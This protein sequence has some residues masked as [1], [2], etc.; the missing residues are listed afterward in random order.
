MLQAAQYVQ[1]YLDEQ[2]F[3]EIKIKARWFTCCTQLNMYSSISKNAHALLPD[4]PLA[5]R[6]PIPA[7]QFP[8]WPAFVVA[9]LRGA[10]HKRNPRLVCGSSLERRPGSRGTWTFLFQGRLGGLRGDGILPQGKIVA[11]CRESSVLRGR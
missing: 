8:D 3:C 11:V 7:R 6:L 5:E 9:G 1:Q 2:V 10:A 4:C